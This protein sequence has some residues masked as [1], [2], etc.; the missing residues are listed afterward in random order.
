MAIFSKD[1]GSRSGSDTILHTM[2]VVLGPEMTPLSWD[3][4]SFQRSEISLSTVVFLLFFFSLPGPAGCSSGQNR[5]ATALGDLTEWANLGRT[6][7]KGRRNYFASMQ[8]YSGSDWEERYTRTHPSNG[9]LFR[10]PEVGFAPPH[11]ELTLNN[12]TSPS[13]WHLP[14]GINPTVVPTP[15]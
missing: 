2:L 12:L 3:V 7:R 15:R 11:C 6:D 9:S 4:L 10:R 8:S 5:S 14:I 13:S 1:G